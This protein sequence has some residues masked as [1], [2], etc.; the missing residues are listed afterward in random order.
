LRGLGAVHVKQVRAGVSF[1]GPLETA[2]RA[3]LW[4]RLATRVLLP[5]AN[6][7]AG[8]GDE[9]YAVAREVDWGRHLGPDDTLAVDFSG[10]NQRIRDTRYGAVR[11]KDAIVDQIRERSGG[12]RPSVD[13][14]T[15]DVR[16]NVHLAGGR[17]TISLDLS[18]Q[19]LH[20]RGYRA[21]RVQVE[22]P[23]K[24]NLA[25][26]VLLY[27]AWPKE[28]AAGGS[29]LDPLC[30]SG[31]LPIEAALMAADIAPGLL[32]AEAPQAPKEPPA[33]G[34]LRWRGHDAA[35]WTALVGEARERRAAGLARQA[36]RQEVSIRGADR[37]ARAVRVAQDCVRRAGLQDLVTVDQAE[38][39]DAGA[40]SVRGLVAVNAPYGERLEA[41]EAEAVYRELGERLRTSFAGWSAVVLAG[42]RRQLGTV[43][44]AAKR[45]TDLRNGPLDCVLAYFE[46]GAAAV[47][48]AAPRSA[49]ATVRSAAPKTS[50]AAGHDAAASAVVAADPAVRPAAGPRGLLGGGAEYLANRLRKNQRRLARRLQREGITCY[51]LY[52]ADL[53]EYNL[54]VDVYGDWVH[55]AEYAAPAEIDIAKAKR[56]LDEALVVIGAV[57]GAPPERV[58]LKQRRRQRGAAQY[59]RR[60]DKSR[61][62]AVAEDDLRYFIDLGTYLDTGF[63]VD[64]RATRRLV[65]RLAGGR[66]FLNLFAYTGT[67]T[68]NAL[69]GGAAASTSV[70]LS[71]TYLAWAERN[72][73]ANGFE[74]EREEWSP[75]TGATATGVDGR[76]AGDAPQA[77]TGHVLV[78]AD[79]LR[80]IAEADGQFDLIWLDPPS[81]SN[82]KRM[83]R[84][85]FDVQRDHADLVR[86]VARRLLAPAGVLL[87]A[88][89]LRNFRL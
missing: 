29:L 25:A 12:R 16:V 70:D 37:D 21:D 85:T 81:F 86:L 50:Q 45:D 7:T 77:P 56:R 10:T 53:P 1:S 31:T 54:V 51:R 36:A 87:F 24:E 84:A 23:L 48:A 47:G 5:L 3:C 18:G 2:Y 20:R 66:R 64:Q 72:L 27:A 14:R 89:N 42:D 82:S 68:V 17:V 59:E 4:S 88:T 38:L 9:L 76:S 22:A 52:D 44:L 61:L 15:P 60:G 26:G 79:C 13:P 11:V 19:S 34:F 49:R 75:G 55:V 58:V 62:L 41:G 43:G 80:W 46:A 74:T 67:M 28:A 40:P 71:A 6:G 30:G 65:R 78:Q 39:A 73:A 35:A 32:R 57:L 33:F 8:D 83:G 69:T 63:F